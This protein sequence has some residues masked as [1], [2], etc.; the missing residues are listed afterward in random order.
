MERGFETISYGDKK[1][2]PI[3][4]TSQSA[5]YDFIIPE[6]ITIYSFEIHIINTG[7]KAFMPKNEYLQISI[8]SSLGKKGLIMPN[9]VGIIDSDYYNNVENEGNIGILLLNI[10]KVP[11]VLLAGDRIA[12]GI[13]LKYYTTDD[14]VKELRSGGFGSTNKIYD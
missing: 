5:G 3:R 6:K 13:F 4:K 2:I 12:Q 8:R 1:Y 9:G 10:S 14:T 11:I 7:I